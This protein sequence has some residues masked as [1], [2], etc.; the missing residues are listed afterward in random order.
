MVGISSLKM[1]GYSTDI[2]FWVDRGKHPVI[3][4]VTHHSSPITNFLLEY[5]L[6]NFERR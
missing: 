5:A 2:T 4:C 3:P 6:V 1:V